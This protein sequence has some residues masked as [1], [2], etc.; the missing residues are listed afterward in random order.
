MGAKKHL[1]NVIN[2]RQETLY[3]KTGIIAITHVLK[4]FTRCE[5]VNGITDNS[6][7][8]YY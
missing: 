2:G 7:V 3:Y 5:P 1:Y 6:Y 4:R 8:R